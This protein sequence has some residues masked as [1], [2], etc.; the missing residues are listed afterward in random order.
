MTQRQA[1][2]FQYNNSTKTVRIFD[3]NNN[4]NANAGC[5][6]TGVAVLSAPGYPN[7]VCTTIVTT[8]PLA[9]GGNASELT[10]GIPSGITNTTLDDG[11]TLTA[12]SGS[13]VV[14]IT[15]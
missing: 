5:N 1:V 14:N 8:V 12:L 11:D 10:Y 13:G 7:N 9:T 15:F 3:H 4:N 2:T 6:M